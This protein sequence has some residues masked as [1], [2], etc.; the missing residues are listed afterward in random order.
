MDNNTPEIIILKNP[1]AVAE[2][3]AD[4]FLNIS[5]EAKKENRI[6][7]ISLSGGKTPAL[8]FKLLSSNKYKQMIIW[9]N[10]NLWWGDERT[11]PPDDPESNFG[12]T[13]KLLL[14]KTNIPFLNIHR[15]KGEL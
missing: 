9:Q 11:V 8:L 4:R 3:A 12:N 2:Y 14:S 13:N 6:K 10:I 15:I 7:H 5:A 1:G